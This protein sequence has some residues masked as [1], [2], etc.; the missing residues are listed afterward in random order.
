VKR[1]WIAYKV[2]WSRN[3]IFVCYWREI[4]TWGVGHHSLVY[5]CKTT[6]Y[7]CIVC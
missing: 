7:A 3:W 6:R 5:F 4:E 1:F 2:N